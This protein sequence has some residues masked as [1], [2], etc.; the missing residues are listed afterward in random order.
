M[1]GLSLGSA[2]LSLP[3]TSRPGARDGCGR[4]APSGRQQ[5]LRLVISPRQRP[6]ALVPR[7]SGLPGLQRPSAAARAGAGP[8]REDEGAPGSGCLGP[9]ERGGAGVRVSGSWRARGGSLGHEDAHRWRGQGSHRRGAGRAPLTWGLDCSLCFVCMVSLTGRHSCDCQRFT[10]GKP[11]SRE[12][13]WAAQGGSRVATF[14]FQPQACLRPAV[15]LRPRPPAP[16][17]SGRENTP[18]RG[19]VQSQL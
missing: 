13:K 19:E 8:F 5:E 9:G 15:A 17:T 7:A 16:P 2:S 18:R 1:R 11:R 12:W 3:A 4:D 14:S 6:R 10:Q